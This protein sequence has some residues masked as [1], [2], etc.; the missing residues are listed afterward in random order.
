MEKT[1]VKNYEDQQPE[2]NLLDLIE[3]LGI[4]RT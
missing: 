3:L 2:L 4:N 1:W